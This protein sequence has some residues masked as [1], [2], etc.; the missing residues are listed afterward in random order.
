MPWEASNGILRSNMNISKGLTTLF[1]VFTFSLLT[2]KAAPLKK[3]DIVGV[4]V[5]GEKSLSGAFTIGSTG[6][7][8]FP[9]LGNIDAAGK[10]T[11][12]VA[13]MIE[14]G[15]E[16]D[17]IR[18]AQVVVEM[19]EEAVAP[20]HTVTVIGQVMNPQQVS[21]PAEGSL[22]IFTAIASAG[23]LSE[24]ANRSRIE[25]KRR[26]GDKLSS[27]IL[28]LDGNRVFKLNDGDTLIVPA[29]PAS[30]LMKEQEV[31]IT[32]LGQ[33]KSPGNIKMDPKH[34]FDLIAAIAAA[35]GF[36]DKAR[37]SKVI[38]R[39]MAKSYEF[40]VTKMQRSDGERFIIQA[41]DIITIPE[42]I[43]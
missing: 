42:S 38:V 17:Y 25:L 14:A 20:P 32:L 6:Q 37:P 23:G 8:V 18:D 7:L 35:G 39:R 12:D 10:T 15:L 11:S 43:F 27:Q 5:F 28:S 22:D 33:V 36:T 16:A 30:E 26:I 19:A 13:T 1:L 31:T 21:F 3:G 24:R 40:N 4:N 41:G 34:P 29:V 2:A 9:L